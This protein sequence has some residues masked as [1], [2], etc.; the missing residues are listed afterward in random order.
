MKNYQFKTSLKCSGCVQAITEPLNN[1]TGV[2]E[3]EVDLASSDKVLSL[4]V[5]EALEPAVIK[6]TLADAGFQ[7]ELL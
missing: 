7:S 3:W 2:E 4:T 5:D 6:K 1:L